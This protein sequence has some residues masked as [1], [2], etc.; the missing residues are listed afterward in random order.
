[1]Q[2]KRN[3]S[4][5]C[6]IGNHLIAMHSQLHLA[7]DPTD[8]LAGDG[9]AATNPGRDP[10]VKKSRVG[11]TFTRD[12]LGRHQCVS[13]SGPKPGGPVLFSGFLTSREAIRC[14]FQG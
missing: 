13:E 14:T 7:D 9:A 5:G 12:R 6:V 3:L 2:A 4:G 11:L 10:A 8:F 1:M